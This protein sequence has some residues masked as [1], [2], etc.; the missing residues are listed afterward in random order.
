MQRVL[1]VL[2]AL[3]LGVSAFSGSGAAAPTWAPVSTAKIRPGVQMYTAGAQCTA[4]FVFTDAARNVYVGYAAHCAGKGDSNDVNGCTTPSNPLGT[5][6]EFRTG[7]TL[8]SAGALVGRGTLV[9]SSWLAMQRRRVSHASPLCLWN[10]FALVRVSA[11]DRGK[12]NPTVP[13][14][15]GPASL[16]GPVLTP[17]SPLYTLGNSSLRFG[18]G[19]GTA[20]T[21]SVIRRDASGYGYQI[22]KSGGGIPGDSGSGFLDARGRARGVLST[23]TIG[24][25]IG[26]LVTN[27]IGDLGFEVAWA[28]QVWLR[29]LTLVPGT[30]PFRTS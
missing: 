18:T 19:F 11:A 12:V 9:Y 5:T 17:R 6:V 2:L 10:D 22:K 16:G 1:V 7:G 29:S 26:G 4:N 30:Q 3:L 25:G 23:L 20:K 24:L 15:G 27:T 21:G 14:W 13:H 8:F 28:R